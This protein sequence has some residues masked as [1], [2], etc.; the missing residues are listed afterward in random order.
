MCL[1]ETY[2]SDEDEEG[3]QDGV[4][5]ARADAA[6]VDD[7]LDVVDED[8]GARGLVRVAAHMRMSS[9]S[10]GGGRGR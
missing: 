5:E 1:A 6:V 3:L 2:L 8:D 7:A 10:R 9:G 4:G